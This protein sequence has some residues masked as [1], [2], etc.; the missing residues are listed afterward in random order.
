MHHFVSSI[1][2]LTFNHAYR[3]TL[4][5]VLIY[6]Y[7][8]TYI[9]L[10][11]TVKIL[12]QNGIEWLIKALLLLFVTIKLSQ[13]LQKSGVYAIC[14]INYDMLNQIIELNLIIIMINHDVLNILMVSIFFCIMNLNT[15]QYIHSVIY[16]IVAHLQMHYY[17]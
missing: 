5:N 17:F 10:K 11:I 14:Y 13:R 2:Q 7:I 6:I 8:Y 12:H 16:M 4:A 3:T 15:S 1:P 9:C